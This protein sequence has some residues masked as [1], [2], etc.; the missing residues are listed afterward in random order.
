M[1]ELSPFPPLPEDTL[2]TR[3]RLTRLQKDEFVRKTEMFSDV[4][5]EDLFQ[6]AGMALETEFAQGKVIFRDSELADTFYVI[7]EGEVELVSPENGRREII[8]P[9]RCFGLYS[10]LTRELRRATATALEPTL[11]IAIEGEEL[12]ILL[13]ENTE[14]F[15]TVIRHFA[16]KCLTPFD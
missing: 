4:A 1:D 6:V 9:G 2:S 11:A 10:A 16:K 5:V 3:A 14:I 15:A 13:S 8:G 12:F 7:A